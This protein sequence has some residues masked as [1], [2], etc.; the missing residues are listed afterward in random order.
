M[1]LVVVKPG[2]DP[3]RSSPLLLQPEETLLGRSSR[4]YLRDRVTTKS[5]PH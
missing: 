5:L 2:E 4:F 3:E 1:V